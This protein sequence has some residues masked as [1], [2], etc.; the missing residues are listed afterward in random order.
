MKFPVYQALVISILCET[1]IMSSLVYIY[2]TPSIY[3]PTIW[4][5]KGH[6][7]SIVGCFMIKH[8]LPIRSMYGI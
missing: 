8:I 4:K 6:T 5:L 3:V 1:L 7:K 2:Q